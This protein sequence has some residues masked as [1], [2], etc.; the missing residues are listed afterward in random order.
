MRGPLAGNKVF[1]R[2][3][4]AILVVAIT[5]SAGAD[6]VMLS[7]ATVARYANVVFRGTSIAADSTTVTFKIERV[8]KGAVSGQFTAYL[9]IRGSERFTPRLHEDYLVFAHRPTDVERLNL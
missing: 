6:C 9:D 1:T 3:S 5:Q 8:W 4:V 7:V 2:L